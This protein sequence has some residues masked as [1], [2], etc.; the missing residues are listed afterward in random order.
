MVVA[1]WA[2]K[3]RGVDTTV[4]SW[5]ASQSGVKEKDFLLQSRKQEMKERGRELILHPKVPKYKISNKSME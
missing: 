3:Y 4:G 1:D 2:K 5:Q